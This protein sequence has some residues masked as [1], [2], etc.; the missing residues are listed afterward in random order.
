MTAKIEIIPVG[1]LGEFGMN[2]LAIRYLDSIIVIDAGLMF[3]DA[4]H[5]GVD[6][7]IPDFAYLLKNKNCV[8]A[9]VLTHSHEDHIGAVPYLL[10][11]INVP[12]Y[13]TRYTAA[14][15]ASKL[16]EHALIEDVLIHAVKPRQKFTVG[17]FKIEFIHVSHSTV[18]CVALAIE[19]PVGT[20]VHTGDYKFDDSPVCD[21][22]TDIDSLRQYGDKGVLA[23]LSDSTNAERPGRMHSESAVIPALE[24]IFDKASGRIIFSCFTSSIHRIQILFDIAAQFGRRVVTL[25]RSMIRNVE[26]AEQTRMLELADGI[27][28]SPN[29]ISRTPPEEIV[30]L[31]TG[32][33]GEP[34]S[35]LSRLAVDN[36]K[37]LRILPGDT[38]VL[39]ARQIPGNEKAI[40][41][42]INHLYRCGA[43]VFD[44]TSARVHVSG[45]G[46]QEDLRLMLEAVRPKFFIPIHGEYRQLFCHKK[47]AIKLGFPANHIILIEDGQVLALDSTSAEV[48]D[49]LEVG[50][51]FVDPT[52]TSLIEDIIVKDRKQLAY[53]GIILP[54]LAINEATGEVESGPEVVVKGFSF[55]EQEASYME[56]LS[57]IAVGTVMASSPEE[58]KNTEALKEKI[59]LELKRYIQRG[60]GKKPIILPVLLQV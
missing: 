2:C 6:I 20:I 30:M 57:K 15:L 58:R 1:G 28:L 41:R 36:Y 12:I 47:F 40:S 48:I 23:L 37:Q 51:L 17:P 16:E 11:Q 27:T 7:I 53:D 24:D 49:K 4:S 60:S 33:Q 22:P 8:D 21:E 19:T 50:K 44:S 18:G 46:A 14:V 3:P 43:E 38:V 35:V 25:G 56:K 45:H 42:L 29:E 52:G 59:R 10:K 5:P 55:P 32:C 9:L 39:S 54:I 26:V 13:A 31:V 34:T